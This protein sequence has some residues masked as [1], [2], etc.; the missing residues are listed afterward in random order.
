MQFLADL[1]A[2]P[3]ERPEI[4]ETTALGAAYLTG[5]QAGLYANASEMAQNWARDQ[6]FEPSM[7]ADERDDRYAGWRDAVRRTRTSTESCS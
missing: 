1:L 5:L 7:A 2:I 4:T 6:L 3:V